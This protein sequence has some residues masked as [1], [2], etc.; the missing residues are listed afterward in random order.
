[1]ISQCALRPKG[2]KL[3]KQELPIAFGAHRFSTAE[4]RWGPS[5]RELIG[6]AKCLKRYEAYIRFGKFI[7]KIDCSALLYL[8]EG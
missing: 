2:D 6:L 1:M 5:A 3:V 7:V 8:K 4:R